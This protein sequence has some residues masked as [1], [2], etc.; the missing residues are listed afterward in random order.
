ML[1]VINNGSDA[2]NKY[3]IDDVSPSIIQFLSLSCSY[4]KKYIQFSQQKEQNVHLWFVPNDII[5]HTYFHE[6][7]HASMIGSI[8]S[9]CKENLSNIVD[10]KILQKLLELFILFLAMKRWKP[11]EVEI[12]TLYLIYFERRCIWV[13]NLPTANINQDN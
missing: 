7:F 2:K 8:L 12:Y 10:E 6:I 3:I 5:V 9:L 1:K 4:L 11:I 13:I